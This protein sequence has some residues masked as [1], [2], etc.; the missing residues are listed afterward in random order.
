MRKYAFIT[1]CVVYMWIM[2]F[3]AIVFADARTAV[4][5]IFPSAWSSLCLLFL[6]NS[7]RRLDEVERKLRGK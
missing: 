2:A 6:I 3:V 1:A 7:D 4:M 5:I